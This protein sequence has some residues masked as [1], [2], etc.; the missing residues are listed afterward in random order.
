MQKFNVIEKRT[1]KNLLIYLHII[2]TFSI[3]LT[4]E[5]WAHFSA[6]FNIYDPIKY[7]FWNFFSKIVI[8]FQQKRAK[9]CIIDTDS[10]LG[11]RS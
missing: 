8:G 5:I 11:S 7:Q 2:S 9:I 10:A 1:E 3:S 4:S 6:F